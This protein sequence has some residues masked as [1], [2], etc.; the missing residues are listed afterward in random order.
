MVT[1]IFTPDHADD[2]AQTCDIRCCQN[3]FAPGFQDSLYFKKNGKRIH[4]Q[5]FE[6]LAEQDQIEAVL[7]IG[8]CFC[9]DIEM[10][11]LQAAGA[12]LSWSY[13]LPPVPTPGLGLYDGLVAFFVHPIFSLFCTNFITIQISRMFFSWFN[14][15]IF[16]SIPVSDY[17]I[18]LLSRY[19]I[20]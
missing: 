10:V 5:M 1:D 13:S 6:H 14:F 8:K 3:K 19:N 2:I 7:L 12:G 17:W 15:S 9:F 11:K 16:Y 18:N 20:N 4:N